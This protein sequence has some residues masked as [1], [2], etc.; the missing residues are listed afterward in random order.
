MSL[1]SPFDTGRILSGLINLQPTDTEHSATQN[2]DSCNGES[3]SNCLNFSSF[4]DQRGLESIK[5]VTIFT[6]EEFTGVRM[7]T[8]ELVARY[9]NTGSDKKAPVRGRDDLFMLL[10]VLKNWQK[11]DFMGMPFGI[12][13]STSDRLS[14][15]FFNAFF[16]HTHEVCVQR[17]EKKWKIFK[18]SRDRKM[19]FSLSCTCQVS[20]MIVLQ[21][22]RPTGIVLKKMVLLREPKAIWMQRR[23]ACKVISAYC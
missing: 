23:S 11:W 10:I 15:R 20:E 13:W 19:F 22:Y 5:S 12:N 2:A 17:T 4:Y 3:W 18:C 16:E 9:W 7:M 8:T 1:S 14:V 6:L 21:G